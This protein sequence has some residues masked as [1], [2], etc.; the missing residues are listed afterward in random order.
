LKH[1]TARIKIQ[2]AV[3]ET[4]AVERRN[5]KT[6]KLKICVRYKLEVLASMLV[7]RAFFMG[8]LITALFDDLTDAEVDLK[9]W[10]CWSDFAH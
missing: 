8:M 2:T 4:L 3:Q 10:C 7:Q 9:P 5:R 6:C 1:P